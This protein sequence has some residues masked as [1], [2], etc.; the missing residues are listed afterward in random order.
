MLPVS[1]TDDFD[2]LPIPYR[3]VA[4]DLLMGSEV[5]LERGSLAE[6]IRASMSIP[7]A[8][9]PVEIGNICWT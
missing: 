1:E 3:A 5:I 8:F 7:G 4:A 2:Q 9:A 6:S